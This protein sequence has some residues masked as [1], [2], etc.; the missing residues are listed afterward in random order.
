MGAALVTGGS[1]RL[2]GAMVRH[3]ASQGHDVVIHYHQSAVDAEVLA[4][5]LMEAY[6][7]SVQTVQG[8][9][10]DRSRVLE[11]VPEAAAKLGKPLDILINNA[12]VMRAD[13]VDDQPGGNFDIWDDNFRTNLEAPFFLTQ[14]F[15]AQCLGHGAI[16]NMI[17]QRVWRPTPNYGSYSLAKSALL[18]MTKTAAQALAP[19]IR[20]NAIGPGTTLIG[21]HQP[22]EN[23]AHH[24]RVSVLQRGADVEDILQALDYLLEARV[25]T[26]QMIAV[27]G[28]QHLIW[29]LP[30]A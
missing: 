19:H 20:V 8:D 30:K 5:E 25:V 15:A 21:A 6:D 24:R 23:F 12:S 26:G 13:R 14:A 7:V 17:D 22:E 18:T 29:E 16:V 9:L 2:G 3:L 10:R 1:K 27:D 4:A 11:I 28:G